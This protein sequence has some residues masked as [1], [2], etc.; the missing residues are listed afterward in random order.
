M[1][2]QNNEKLK[3]ALEQVKAD[4]KVANEKERL[5]SQEAAVIDREAA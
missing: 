4:T 5:V 2:Q 1:L 3:I